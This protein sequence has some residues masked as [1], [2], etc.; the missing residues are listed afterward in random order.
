M[1]GRLVE[2]G[3]KFHFTIYIVFNLVL[4]WYGQPQNLLLHK[5]IETISHIDM[6]ALYFSFVCLVLCNIIRNWNRSHENP[7]DQF[8]MINLFLWLEIDTH[9]GFWLH[10]AHALKWYFKRGFMFYTNCRNGRA[11]Y[12]TIIYFSC[13]MCAVHITGGVE[14]IIFIASK[15][16]AYIGDVVYQFA[17]CISYVV[18]RKVSHY[19]ILYYVVRVLR[20]I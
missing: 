17:P 14:H 2:V 3:I 20:L 18:L 13:I 15:L 6:D 11:T 8:N 12:I 10:E 7:I 16:S 19:I 9:T 1:T 5:L 4:H